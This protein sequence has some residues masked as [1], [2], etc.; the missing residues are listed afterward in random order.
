MDRPTILQHVIALVAEIIGIS[1]KK[2]NLLRGPP[3]IFLL[4]ITETE[5]SRGRT[6][7]FVRSKARALKSLFIKLTFSLKN[8][9]SVSVSVITVLDI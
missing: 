8:G 7:L 3:G 5:I 6:S 2:V 4:Y 1:L 9:R